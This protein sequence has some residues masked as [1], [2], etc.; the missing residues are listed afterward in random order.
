MCTAVVGGSIH[1]AATRISAASDQ[2]STTPMT[3]HRIKDRRKS[4]RRGV[5]VSLFGIAVTFQNNRLGWVAAD[6]CDAAFLVA[7]PKSSPTDCGK[8]S[9]QH[10]LCARYPIATSS[11]HENDDKNPILLG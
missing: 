8:L 2:R 4:A 9:A 7:E 11:E 5:L 10:A 3:S 6:G 1:R